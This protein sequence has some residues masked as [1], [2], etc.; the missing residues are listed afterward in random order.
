MQRGRMRELDDEER[1]MLRRLDGVIPTPELIQMVHDLSE[2]L[3]K[4]GLVLRAKV[5]ELA[6]ARLDSLQFYR[7]R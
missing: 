4:E 2:T 7:K 3:A 5:A 1:E 6:A